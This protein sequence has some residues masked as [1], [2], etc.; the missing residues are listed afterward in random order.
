MSSRQCDAGCSFRSFRRSTGM[1]LTI[2]VVTAIA[3]LT[4]PF[5]A[6]TEIVPKKNSQAEFLRSQALRLLEEAKL[7]AGTL[8]P[9]SA[10][11]LFLVI[12]QAYTPVDK[13]K[14]R[15]ALEIAYQNMRAAM[16]Q[17]PDLVGFMAPD[18]I[19]ATVEAA[20]DTVEQNLPPEKFRDDAL[21]ALVT[22]H[23]RHDKD[24]GRA[25]DLFL[26]MQTDEAMTYAA[27][28]L[29]MRIPSARQYDRDRVF[30]AV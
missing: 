20:P 30:G 8:E 28:D 25:L 21:A 3:V 17:S 5:A 24:L 6:S 16:E 1:A 22:Y 29:L 27:R 23:L 19:S 13:K 12:G 2:F 9:A 10:A 11:G 14:A 15:E 4:S 18:L 7:Q 26:M